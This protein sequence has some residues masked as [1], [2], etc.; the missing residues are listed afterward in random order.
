LAKN[1][2]V[3]YNCK[4]ATVESRCEGASAEDEAGG[5]AELHVKTVSAMA[6]EMQLQSAPPMTNNMINKRNAR[7]A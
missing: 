5:A 2:R 4:I 7:I 1:G 6:Q 3:G